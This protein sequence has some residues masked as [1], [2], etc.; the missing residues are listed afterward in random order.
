MR[1]RARLE[2]QFTWLRRYSPTLGRV[3][4]TITRP[5]WTLVRVPVG[6]MFILGG[7]LAILPIFGLWMI[8]VGLLL[9]AVD[10]PRLRRP[11][12][13]AVIRMRRRAERWKSR[14]KD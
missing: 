7:I 6:M 13:T 2:R 3:V 4:Q 11:V 12:A 9:L 5:G 1:E 10:V 8:P 14:R